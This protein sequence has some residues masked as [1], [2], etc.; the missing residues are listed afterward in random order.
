VIAESIPSLDIT[1]RYAWKHN[2]KFFAFLLTKIIPGSLHNDDILLLDYPEVFE[3]GLPDWRN[4]DISKTIETML[5]TR[6]KYRIL[7]YVVE[8]YFEIK[9]EG[10]GLL[11]IMQGI[12]KNGIPFYPPPYFAYYAYEAGLETLLHFE[13][14]YPRAFQCA[15]YPRPNWYVV[16]GSEELFDAILRFNPEFFDLNNEDNMVYSFIRHYGM[17]FVNRLERKNINF[18][19]EKVFKK[20]IDSNHSEELFAY[21]KSRSYEFTTSSF[22]YALERERSYDL[23]YNLLNGKFRDKIRDKG[24]MFISNIASL[25]QVHWFFKNHLIS[26]EEIKERITFTYGDKQRI[27]EWLFA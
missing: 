1:L 4:D 17:Q 21:L 14:K 7:K 24:F 27:L 23:V 19:L 11:A 2:K 12:E 6:S 26:R 10:T 18:K 13:Q 22:Y 8:E 3:I 15:P 16:E 9:I 25:H 5:Y 20:A